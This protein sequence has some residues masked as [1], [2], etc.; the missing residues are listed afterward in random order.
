MH[1]ICSR[2]PLA[3]LQ[4]IIEFKTRFC[5]ST[6]FAWIVCAL[7][8]REEKNI[9][10]E[11]C[12][13]LA[14]CTVL[15]RLLHLARVQCKIADW[16]HAVRMLVPLRF[17]PAN[18]SRSITWFRRWNRCSARGVCTSYVWWSTQT[19]TDMARSYNWCTTLLAWSCIC[20][21]QTCTCTVQDWWLCWPNRRQ[22]ATPDACF[23]VS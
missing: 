15:M 23:N 18:K 12:L 14:L 22:A 4:G 11:N 10:L 5:R 19:A 8:L 3:K 13:C 17:Q 21:P 9:T 1:Q 6:H 20:F 2:G 7:V 16:E